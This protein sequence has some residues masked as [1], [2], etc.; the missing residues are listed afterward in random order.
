MKRTE[1]KKDTVEK[2]FIAFPDIAADVINVLLY[3]GKEV[4]KAENLLAG[5]TETIYQGWKKQR[6]QY[7]DLCKYELADGRVNIMYLIANQSRTDGK[8]LLRKAGYTG[9]VYREQYEKKTQGIFPVI[10]FVLY[11][12]IPRWRS[13]CNTRRL[14]RGRKLVDEAWKYID[15]LQLHVFEMRHLTKE[16]RALFHSDMRI[17]VDYLAEGNQYRSE[18]KI[19]HKAALIRMIKV[20]SGEMDTENIETWMEEQGIREEDEITVCELFDQYVRQGENR[21]AKLVQM[22]LEGGRNEDIKRA[23]SDQNYREQL[24][25]ETGM[26]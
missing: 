16:T 19:V 11:W 2:E 18:K 4:V 12:G 15:E 24:Y 7:E 3:Q 17:V 21:F 8:M 20:L 14:F 1:E 13:S 23:V 10:E 5:P 26:I 9:G 25:A 6:S 22:L